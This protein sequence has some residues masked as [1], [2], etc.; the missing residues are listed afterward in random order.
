MNRRSFLISAALVAAAPSLAR[1]HSFTL[2]D[3]HIGHPWTRPT[4]A[5]QNAAGYMTLQNNGAQAEALVR[6]E[7]AAARRATLH[8]T[9]MGNGVM[10]MREVPFI[11]VP[12]HGQVAIAPGGF[13]IMLEGLR[14]PFTLG[15]RVPATLVFRRAGRVA[16][17]FV[18][19]AAAPAG[20]DAMPG[21]ADMPGMHH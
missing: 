15:Q 11:A 6:V 14:A 7:C 18:V 9:T 13:H 2:G 5:G 3:L 1:A 10:F 4:A 21:M 16:V 12:P 20:H 19:Q 8:S 17:Q